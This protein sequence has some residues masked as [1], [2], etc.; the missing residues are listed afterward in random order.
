MAS[1]AH[2]LLRE[3]EFHWESSVLREGEV[4]RE[5]SVVREGE[6]YREIS[7]LRE[8]EVHGELSI[9]VKA[10]SSAVFLTC[11]TLSGTRL[12]GEAASSGPTPCPRSTDGGKL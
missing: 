8:G 3:G 12:R 7:V 11:A 6:V 5:I 9:P 10:P 1:E 2:F 4:H